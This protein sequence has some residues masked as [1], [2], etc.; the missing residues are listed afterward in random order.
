MKPPPEFVELAQSFYPG[1]HKKDM[2]WEEWV[3]VIVAWKMSRQREISRKYL[4]E[5]LASNVSDAE[6]KKIWDSTNPTYGF[7]CGIRHFLTLLRDA[8]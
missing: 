7:T 3:A 5:L 1:S 6:L 4:A 8:L 2:T